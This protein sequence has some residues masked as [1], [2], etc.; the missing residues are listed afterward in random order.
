MLAATYHT[1]YFGSTL[2]NSNIFKKPSD[3][4]INIILSESLWAEWTTVYEN[5]ILVRSALLQHT[6]TTKSGLFHLLRWSGKSYICRKHIIPCFRKRRF[7]AYS[8][9]SHEIWAQI[10]VS[11][12]SNHWWAKSRLCDKLSVQAVVCIALCLSSSSLN[13][14]KWVFW[15]ACLLIRIQNYLSG[16][17]VSFRSK[18]LGMTI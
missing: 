1:E 5:W 7:C 12:K 15:K 17:L 6:I 4:E 10:V 8:K 14:V 9:K 13:D 16:I 3:T 18:A 2:K 11:V